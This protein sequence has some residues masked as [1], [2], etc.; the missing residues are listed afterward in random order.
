MSMKRC[1]LFIILICL[2]IITIT[3]AYS[4]S[5]P[6]EAVFNWIEYKFPDLFPRSLTVKE[7]LTHEG[8]HYDLRHWSGAWGTRYLG[9]T[10]NG[11]IIG[12][13]D[14]T[15]WVLV[16]FGD[17]DD[18]E[19]A[20]IS[21]EDAVYDLNFSMTLIV[22]ETP[23][24]SDDMLEGIQ[25]MK[26]SHTFIK[27]MDGI[28]RIF[29]WP[30]LCDR[31]PLLP[32]LEF[33]ETEPDKYVLA[34]T[35]DDVALDSVRATRIMDEDVDGIKRFVAVSHGIEPADV[36]MDGGW[37]FNHVFVA[38][39]YGNGF[40]FQQ[41]S[42]YRSFYHDVDVYDID[43]NGY[44][45]LLV[46]NM[47]VYGGEFESQNLHIFSQY[48]N[49]QFEQV[50]WFEGERQDN[51]G[52]AEFADLN[53]DGEEELIQSAYC[54]YILDGELI[55][56]WGGVRIWKK[57]ESGELSI[58]STIERSG[59]AME[60]GGASGTFVLDYNNDGLLDI[61]LYVESLQDMSVGVALELY[62][63]QDNFNFVRVTDEVFEHNIWSPW[64]KLAAR[65]VA[66][67]DVNND[68]LPDITLNANLG[69][70]IDYD[71]YNR[72]G[73]VDVGTMILINR[74]G[75]NFVQLTNH[76]DLIV[77]T[78]EDNNIL[79]VGFRLM[80]SENG[81][82]KFFSFSEGGAPTVYKVE[83]R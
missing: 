82:T 47:G 36:E 11:E 48:N 7:E 81:V 1:L 23:A 20:I 61:L 9:I 35:L 46:V 64:E 26:N 12:L 45:E 50:D 78:G 71:W 27:G 37:P 25:K 18:F 14:Y 40:E 17:I 33:V 44:D 60:I 72:S 6:N 30:S 38:T 42:D 67:A 75:R 34:R 3:P 51:S 5:L 29:F 57:N 13:G 83:V 63:N 2:L 21:D 41:V 70:L 24:W 19:D 77:N 10:D 79:P 62:E 31:E 32:G 65:E 68:G 80:S 49:G 55:G 59:L 52:S 22:S 74:N 43:G 76:P 53:N 58:V 15:D 54:T 56:E 39:D 69:E 73:H 66:I 4:S 28:N 8:V 16:S